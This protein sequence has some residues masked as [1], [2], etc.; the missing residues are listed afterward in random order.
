MRNHGLILC[1]LVLALLCGGCGKREAAVPPPVPGSAAGAA[2]SGALSAASPPDMES[3]GL[4][5]LPEGGAE[6]GVS[7]EH[8]CDTSAPSNTE[9]PRGLELPE[10]GAEAGASAEYTCD[11]SAVVNGGRTLTLRLHCRAIASVYDT[12]DY[13]VSSIDVLDGGTVLQTLSIH[14]AIQADDREMGLDYVDSEETTRF[15]DPKGGLYT[16]DLNFDGAEDLRLV[17]F[18][19]AA[20]ARYL[21]WL[22]D[23]AA[24]RF[25]YAFGLTGYEVTVAPEAKVLVTES[26]NG[27]AQYEQDTYAYGG[28]GELLHV[29][30]VI[31]D[32]S[33]AGASEGNPVVTEVTMYEQVDGVWVEARKPLPG[34]PLTREELDQANAAFDPAQA[35]QSPSDTVAAQTA[36]ELSCFFTSYYA[37]VRELDF[38]EFLRY[39]P[40]EG[41]TAGDAAE[42]DAL[43]KLPDFPWRAGDFGKETL[44]VQDLPVPVHRIP[45]AS[46]DAALKRYAGITSAELKRTGGALYLP[47]YDAWYNF[48][49]DFGPGYFQAVVGAMD[50]DILRFRSAENGD[51]TELT[52]RKAGGQWYIQSFQLVEVP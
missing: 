19:G 24:G 28:D 7:A 51:V 22:W 34:T 20:N 1:G 10:S 42:F 39:F 12:W 2:V 23:P 45:R 9:S 16:E 36:A 29:R 25:E 32:F 5:E 48:T 31:Q 50:N 33:A 4:S 47:E 40:A 44:T 41:L 8:A 43:S 14:E 17:E 18:M 13:G 15:W 26:R 37:D 49:S 27:A 3:P 6:A 35:V 38:V 52:L 21:C 11:A 46:V 30:R